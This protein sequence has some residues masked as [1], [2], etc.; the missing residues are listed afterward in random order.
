MPSEVQVQALGREGHFSSS[1]WSETEKQKK[2]S[3]QEDKHGRLAVLSHG[4]TGGSCRSEPGVT[5]T[6]GE[7]TC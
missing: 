6:A 3:S 7:T 4:L 1:L 5:M 2:V